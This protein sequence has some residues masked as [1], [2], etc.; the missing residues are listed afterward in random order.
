[1]KLIK[2]EQPNCTNCSFVENFLIDNHVEYTKIDVTKYP[3]EAVKYGVMSVPVVI[4]LDEN[5]NE[6]KRSIGYKPS[7]LES[8]IKDL[9][10]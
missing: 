2:L 10:N 6:I 3:N 7:E 9:N 4:L 1:M 8:I 5:E